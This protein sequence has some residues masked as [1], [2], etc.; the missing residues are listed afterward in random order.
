VYDAIL[1][2][3]VGLYLL[4]FLGAGSIMYTGDRAISAPILLMRALGTCAIIMLHIILAI[5]PLHRLDARFAPLLYNR[6]HFGVTMFLV[7]LAHGA[8]ATLFY[9]AFGDANPLLAVA[10]GYGFDGPVWTW[11]FEIFGIGALAILFLM[12]ATSHDFWL[13]NLTPRWWKWLHMSVYLA[14]GL[15]A[16]HVTFGALQSERSGLYPI[17]LGAGAVILVALHLAAGLKEAR[18]DAAALGL[19]R[20]APPD[21]VDAC[22]LDDIPEDRAAVVCL[23]GHERVA[24]FRHDGAISAI[25]NVC[26]HQGGPLGEGK[27][28]NGCVTC[29]W[30]GYQYLAHN[31][32]SPPPFA[33]KVPTYRVRIEGRRILLN[34][35]ALAPGTP[36]ESARFAPPTPGAADDGGADA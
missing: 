33:E 26:A 8:L 35:E 32:Q 30:H 9:G 34:P 20:A 29:P 18:R 6:R 22:A 4:V 2:G 25:S 24:I 3:G 1:I 5:G 16:L 31:G 13:K 7:A 23:K 19:G 21:W 17:L 36:V 12:A 28:V 14:Y 15:L 10:A 11:P 27:I